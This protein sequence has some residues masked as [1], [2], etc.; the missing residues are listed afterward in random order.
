M[1]AI[2]LSDQEKII[3]TVSIAEIEWPN[4]V[5]WL[6]I[7]IGNPDDWGMDK[8]AAKFLVDNAFN[9]LNLLKLELTVFDF[10]DRAIAFYE[11]LKFKR[12]GTF[13]QLMEREGKRHD[14]H[15][16]GLLQEEWQSE[17]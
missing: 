5:A 1:L 8:E 2:L 15:L 11:K 3:V 14:M 9:E 13:R 17:N 7:G 4:R 16:Y 6:G 12:E 10:N